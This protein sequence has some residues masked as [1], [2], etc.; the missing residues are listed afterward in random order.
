MNDTTSTK[1]VLLWK[2]DN[3]ANWLTTIGLE[4]YVN[5]FKSKL[6]N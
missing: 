3:V 5:K 6:L 2:A 1:E 4:K